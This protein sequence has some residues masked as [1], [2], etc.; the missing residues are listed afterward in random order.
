MN[1]I[2]LMIIGLFTVI[3][4]MGSARSFAKAPDPAVEQG[5][6][7]IRP[8][9]EIADVNDS[10][11][12]S[13]EEMTDILAESVMSEYLD[14]NS[15]FSM[16]YPS[17]FLFDENNSGTCAATEDGRARLSI[18]HMGNY[19]Q[20]TEEMLI[21]AIRL[22]TDETGSEIN[23]L[24]GCI[25]VERNINNGQ[26]CRTDLYLL[27][28]KSLHHITISFPAEE[29]VIFHAYIDYMINSMDTEETELG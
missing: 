4:M 28:E 5:L 18:E 26:T 20:L 16:Q 25:R 11:G 23:N 22:E 27:T 29:M 10:E 12:M 7:E 1:R 2:R 24:N 6:E 14:S 9:M 3:V 19:G 8:L 17:I 15:S 13:L 21:E